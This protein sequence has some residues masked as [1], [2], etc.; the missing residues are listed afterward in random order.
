MTDITLIIERGLVTFEDFL[1]LMDWRYVDVES[2]ADIVS[3]KFACSMSDSFL[4][5]HQRI[6]KWQYVVM[7]LPMTYKFIRRLEDDCRRSCVMCIDYAQSNISVSD[8]L[9]L[10]YSIDMSHWRERLFKMMER[11]LSNCDIGEIIE[12]GN[13]H[14][15]NLWIIASMQQITE[16]HYIQLQR[17]ERPYSY[18]DTNTWMIGIP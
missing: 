15:I 2:R 5:K 16:D 6:L 8:R 9:R 1:K 17:W 3:R 4:L 14:S 12:F 10:L 13:D 7:Q 11:P 18:G